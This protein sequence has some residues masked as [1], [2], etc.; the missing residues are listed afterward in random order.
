MRRLLLIWCLL[1]AGIGCIGQSEAFWQSRDSNYDKKIT[2]GGGAPY[3]GPGDVVSGAMVW[4][5]LR[6]YN[7]AFSGN[8]ATLCDSATGSTSCAN[9][10]WSGSTLTLPN[11]LAAPCN[12]STNI[13][14]IT[15]MFDQTGHGFDV[16]QATLANMPILV[17]SCLGSL[18]CIGS[19][20]STWLTNATGPTGVTNTGSY[21]WVAQQT[22]SSN[23]AVITNV[24]GGS[25]CWLAFLSGPVIEINLNSSTTDQAAV[26]NTWYA[27]QGVGTG[28]VAVV[29]ANGTATSGVVT[30]STILGAQAFAGFNPG[31]GFTGQVT[32]GG[33]WDLAFTAASGGA[34]QTKNMCLNQVAYWGA[35]NSA[36]TGVTC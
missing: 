28:V 13:C 6:G 12:N 14:V 34:G 20:G 5:G 21:S 10:T 9:A 22:S 4:Y 31:G 8:V 23:A 35:G 18:P 3:V 7:A 36:F 32:E 24:C 15:K 33:A 2:A 16:T 19:N 11:I 27:A 25:E 30:T 17:T 1:L 29:S 26:L